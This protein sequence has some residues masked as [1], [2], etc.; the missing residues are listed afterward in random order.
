[1]PPRILITGASS[2][3]G[4][5]TSERLRA[6]GA[7]VAGL[8]L[9]PRPGVILADVRDQRQVDEAV[10]EAIQTLG[11]LDVVVNNAGI[12][13]PQDAGVPPGPDVTAVLETNF[14]GPWRVTAAALPALMASRGRVVNV[15]SG[16]AWVNVP[17]SAAYAASKRA[18][19]AYSDILRH[20][21]GSRITVTTVYPGY[22]RTPIHRPSERVGIS[23]AGAVPEEPLDAAVRA[24]VRASLGPPR[25][26]V[27]TGRLTALGVL[28]GRHLP[29]LMDR[30]VAV[31]ARA[32]ADRGKLV[33]SRLRRAKPRP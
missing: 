15:A 27:F 24:I 16:L 10:G 20:E 17:F 3:F 33:R 26:E 6:R 25:R 8:D 12:G 5:A 31:R 23:L 7:L 30:L 29:A 13:I 11:G 9:R 18:L 4:L 32:L 28:A 1:M 14:L 22:V 21:Y 19:A 2:G